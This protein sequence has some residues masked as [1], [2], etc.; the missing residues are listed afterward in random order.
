[1]GWTPHTLNEL[2]SAGLNS[3]AYVGTSGSPVI[4]Y[5]NSNGST[6]G[7]NP[8][9][10]QSSSSN[11]SNKSSS[12]NDIYGGTPITTNYSTSNT[13]S[14][15]TLDS[16]SY[17]ISDTYS[18]LL[19]MI[20]EIT[21]SNN[22]WSAEQAQKQMDFQTEANRIAMEFNAG[23]AAKNR[24]WQEF[25][26]NTAHQ[27]EVADLKAAGL[28]PVL[29]ASGGN[30]APVGSGATAQ[31]V[32]SAGAK[33]DT[34]E[35]GSTALASIY[36]SILA[37][38]TSMYNQ[39]VSA[40]T[41]L[42]IAEMQQETSKYAAELG[43]AASEYA[44]GTSYAAQ[45]YGY[46]LNY[47]NNQ[48]QRQWNSEHPSNAYQAATSAPVTKTVNSAID[49]VKSIFSGNSTSSAKKKSTSTHVNTGKF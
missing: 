18:D 37:A 41:N 47:K 19:N 48:E 20:S 10:N 31:G 32:T 13:G 22:A 26:S 40:Q 5:P 45:T 49:K 15:S 28:N 38:Q 27:R 25:M 23:E 4:I 6:G 17:S 3:G 1:M 11:S 16:V 24:D 7:S 29:S 36:S 35:S 12:S 30:G 42:K 46:D 2:E 34:D 9:Y 8:N 44:A 39:N 21:A 14:A 33:G 43:A